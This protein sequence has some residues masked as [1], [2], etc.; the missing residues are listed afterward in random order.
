MRVESESNFSLI[1]A[2]GYKWF[3]EGGTGDVVHD[4]Q[5]NRVP[6]PFVIML[7]TITLMIV[8]DRALYLRKAV[9]AKLIYQLVSI[10]LFHIWIFYV[11]PWITRRYG[12]HTTFK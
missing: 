11:L 5:S 4:I 12:I 9:V 7:L 2:F 10:I 6:L 1:I 8:M 3:G